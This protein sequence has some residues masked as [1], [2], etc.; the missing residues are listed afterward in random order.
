MTDITLEELEKEI[1]ED[2]EILAQE[3]GRRPPKTNKKELDTTKISFNDHGWPT[4]KIDIDQ[5]TM[6]VKVHPVSSRKEDELTGDV[7]NALRWKSRGV[8]LLRSRLAL[9]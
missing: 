9:H 1:Q 3:A 8:E 5:K 6:L 2:L 4:I 7:F